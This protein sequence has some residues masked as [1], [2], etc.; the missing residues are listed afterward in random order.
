MCTLAVIDCLHF[1][2]NFDKAIIC[3]DS[4]VVMQSMPHG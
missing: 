3:G 2:D 1:N 4:C